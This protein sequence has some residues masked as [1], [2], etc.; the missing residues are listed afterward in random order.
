MGR[1]FSERGIRINSVYSVG[2][3]R[4]TIGQNQDFKGVFLRKVLAVFE[5]GK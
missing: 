1:K 5:R 4:E 3:H 2:T